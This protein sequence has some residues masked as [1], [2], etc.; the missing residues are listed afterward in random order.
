[1]SVSM[2]V[3][4]DDR[5]NN[6]SKLRLLMMDTKDPVPGHTTHLWMRMMVNELI[7]NLQSQMR[8][9]DDSRRTFVTRELTFNALRAASAAREHAFPD[10]S[11]WEPNDWFTAFAGEVGEAGNIL[12]KIRRKDFTLDEARVILA[13]ELADA[14]IY[15]DWLAWSCGID[16]AEATIQK[17]NEVSDAKGVDVKLP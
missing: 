15:L 14:Q 2:S 9:E 5:Y 3:S 6:I 13:K 10:C 4:V 17:F 1:M 8:A 12:K 16:L 11:D 7:M